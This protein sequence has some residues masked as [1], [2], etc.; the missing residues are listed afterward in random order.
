MM[1]ARGFASAAVLAALSL[2]V[3]SAGPGGR[4]EVPITALW[5]APADVESRDLFNGPWGAR[6]APDPSVT[7]TFVRPKKGGANPGVVVHDPRGRTWHVK[8]PR[9]RT[10]SEGPV[11]VVL[12]RVLSAVGYHQPPVYFLP[13][14]TMADASGTQQV[15]GGRF[16]LE[17][18]SLSDRGSWSWARNP[19]VGTQPYQG[20]LVILLVF[21]SWDLKDSN[22]TLYEID[23][24]GRVDRWY[25]VRDLGGA[26][27]DSGRFTTKRNDIDRFERH[28]FVVGLED[29]FVQ[30]KYRGWHSDLVRGRITV[31]DV[32]WGTALLDRLSEAQWRDAFRA[33][34][35]EPGIA[36]RFIRKIRS[37]IAAG[38]QLTDAAA[39]RTERHR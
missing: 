26:L 17:D 23:R 11:E 19:F 1:R 7:Y 3:T 12:S 38:Q 18:A 31:E 9:P 27:G 34:G 24:G 5:E 6:H 21:N 4:E 28:P 36:E 37:N 2:C 33:G 22:N 29:G 15:P 10:G 14:F 39:P 16:R 20:L 25:V 32:R 13:S 30:F 8:Q 35:Y